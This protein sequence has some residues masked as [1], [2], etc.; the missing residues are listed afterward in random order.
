MKYP[1]APMVLGIILGDLLYKNMRRDLV[2]TD[3]DITPFQKALTASS[4]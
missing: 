4:L 2:L 1:M 3:G